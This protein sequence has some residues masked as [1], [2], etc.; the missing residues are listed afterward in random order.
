MIKTSRAEALFET[1]RDDGHEA[2]DRLI[3]DRVAEE[4]FLDFKRSA[5]NGAGDTLHNRD[6]RNLA[7]AV[8]GFGNAEGGIIVWG[9]DCSDDGQTGDLPGQKT[10][11]EDPARFRAN[12][13]SAISG[14]TV[15]PHS[16][17]ENQVIE[18]SDESPGLVVTMVPKAHQAPLQTVNDLRFLVRAGSSF[19]PMPHGMVA[20]MFGP[21]PA[22][23]YFPNYVMAVAE[24]TADEAIRV[25]FGIAIVN[26]GPGL[27]EN[28]YVTTTFHSLPGE[29]TVA[30]FETPDTANWSG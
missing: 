11:I 18:A 20:S 10:G 7:K 2:I 25:A 17:V 29:E 9:G 30:R 15:P 21:P 27:A 1:I 5:D 6:R 22:P 23:H 28:M 12:I 13:E 19:V 26:D 14:C 3:Q 8:C 16:K 4:L 24:I